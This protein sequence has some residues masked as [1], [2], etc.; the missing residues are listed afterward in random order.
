MEKPPTH[1]HKQTSATIS[2]GLE[3]FKNKPEI[4]EARI[5]GAEPPPFLR[6]VAAGKTV[7]ALFEP[8][9]RASN[10]FVNR[11]IWNGDRRG[12]I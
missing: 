5:S 4:K 2:C 10:A 3:H 1:A 12:V 6:R 9:C 7:A 8:S 11:M